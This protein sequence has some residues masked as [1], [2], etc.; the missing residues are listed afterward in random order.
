MRFSIPSGR[1][2]RLGKPG[3]ELQISILAV[4]KRK[5][6]SHAAAGFDAFHEAD[7]LDRLLQLKIGSKAS[8]DPERIGGFDE[9]TIGA[10]IAGAGAKDCGAPLDIQ[11]RV[12]VVTRRPATFQPA[13]GCVCD[14]HLPDET[15]WL[16][17]PAKRFHQVDGHR[18]HIRS[19]AG[20]SLGASLRLPR[21]P[22]YRVG[23][24]SPSR[25]HPRYQ[26]QW[27]VHRIR[28][29]SLGRRWLY[30]QSSVGDGGRGR[31]LRETRRTRPRHG[32][33]PF[34]SGPPG[35]L[36]AAHFQAFPDAAFSLTVYSSA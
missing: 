36:S 22:G 25:Q 19:Q 1:R 32:S 11:V 24:R 27:Y 4:R 7:D 34:V 23:L 28:R 30:C 13:S 12:E 16:G 31:L 29:S 2:R 8:A 10:D 6:D 14:A 18:R 20:T 9:H 21:E 26:L 35:Y 3:N 15:S 33:L 17:N 5:G